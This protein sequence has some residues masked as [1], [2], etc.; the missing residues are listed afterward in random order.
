[1]SIKL[2]GISK[3]FQ[4]PNKKVEVFKNVSIEIKEKDMLII[5]GPSGAGKTTLLNIIGG[6]DKPTV[7]KISIDDIDLGTLNS[8]DLA[9][10]RKESIGFIFQSFNLLPHLSAKDNI[11]LPILLDKDRPKKIRHV[12]RFAKEIGIEKRLDHLPSELSS[13]EQQ[14]V[15]ITRAMANSP[16]IILADEPTA[17]LD[18]D[19]AQ[20]II[21]ILKGLNKKRGCTVLMA[22]NDERTASNF[23]TR[24]D[25]V[26]KKIISAK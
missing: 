7:G 2:E 26:N 17:D 22:T 1:M 13:G 3:T 20:K 14:R 5:F 12:L 23:P 18:D 24:F 19:N 11:I 6:M 9:K 25:L 21:D 15:A 10:L 8:N 16:S 4:I